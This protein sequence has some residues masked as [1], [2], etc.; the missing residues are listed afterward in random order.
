[1]RTDRQDRHEELIVAFRSFANAPKNKNNG[2]HWLYTPRRTNE[3]SWLSWTNHWIY[4]HK[5][6]KK[7][8]TRVGCGRIGWRDRSVGWNLGIVTM[9]K[10]EGRVVL[11]ECHRAVTIQRNPQWNNL[12]C[13]FIVARSF[14]T[15]I[16]E[17]LILIL[18]SEKQ[19]FYPQLYNVFSLLHAALTF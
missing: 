15:R 13:I 5:K 11:K 14:K 18:V 2:S 9:R 19:M 16:Q 10:R 12:L 8:K 7:K 1:M 3:T 6:K 4:S 17:I